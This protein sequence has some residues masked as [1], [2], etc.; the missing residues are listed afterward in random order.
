VK[1]IYE[2]HQL[3]KFC[4]TN[5]HNQNGV[6]E[7]SINTIIN[8]DRSMILHDSTHWKD[9]SDASPWPQSVTYANH[10]Y[11]RT[12]KDGTCPTD[13]FTGSLVTRHCFMD[14]HIWGCTVYVPDPKKQQGKKLPR[15]APR[16]KRGLFLRLIQKH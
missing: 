4:V 2:T 14:L 3:I 15:W 11:D 10:V 5:A 16:S 9:G 12:P 8:M 7:I 1:H 6:A 13:I